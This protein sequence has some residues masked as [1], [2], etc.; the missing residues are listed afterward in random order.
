MKEVKLKIKN[1]QHEEYLIQRQNQ[2]HESKGLP[3]HV[4]KELSNKIHELYYQTR[5]AARGTSGNLLLMIS[6]IESQ[7]SRYIDCVNT[8]E[9][10]DV[11]KIA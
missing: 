5:S 7:L 2:D 10:F 3:P 11:K 4:Q 6:E 1:H 9:Q 8:L